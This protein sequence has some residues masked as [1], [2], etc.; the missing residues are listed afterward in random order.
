MLIV[1]G[2]TAIYYNMIIAW[3]IYYIF[4]SVSNL[5]G[6][7]WSSC[8]QVW[9]TPCKYE[10]H[11]IYLNCNTKHQGTAISISVVITVEYIHVYEKQCLEL[12]AFIK[13]KFV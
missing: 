4:A 13:V 7:P 8:S 2:L 10:I 1:S 6:V 3:A 9:A 12:K 11:Q 5:P